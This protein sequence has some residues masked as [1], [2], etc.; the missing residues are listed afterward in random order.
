MMGRLEYKLWYFTLSIYRYFHDYLW[1]NHDI[2][3][4][5]VNQKETHTELY[6]I[7]VLI[8]SSVIYYHIINFAI[9]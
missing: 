5:R 8:C 3:V 2:W 7:S 6:M 4:G 9:I 1:L